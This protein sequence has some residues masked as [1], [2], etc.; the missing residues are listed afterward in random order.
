MYEQQGLPLVMVY[1]AA[2][3]GS[4]DPK[5]CGRYI[6]NFARHRMPA[7]VLVNAPFCFVYVEDVCRAIIKA[8]MKD[9]NIGE[10][11]LVSGA[12][13]TFGEVNKIVCDIAGVS[14][15]LLHLPDP[16]TV[17]N[18]RLLTAISDLIKVRPLL[19]LSVDQ[20]AMM[21][22]GFQVDASKTERELGIRYTPIRTAFENAVASC[23]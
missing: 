5:A 6:K 12:N 23:T 20:I 3:I 4:N 21:K 10:K 14:L 16:L 7:Q 11:Y 1:P 15:P 13:L 2:V 17:I 9:D 19:D 8:L 18:A 22:Q